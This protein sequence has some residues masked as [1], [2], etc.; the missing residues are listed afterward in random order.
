[1]NLKPIDSVQ[2]SLERL[3]DKRKKYLLAFSSGGDSV[4]LLY[5]LSFYFKESLKDHIAL[6]YINYH[7]SGL[8]KKK[9]ES[10]STMSLFLDYLISEKMST[11]ERTTETLK[12]GH[13]DSVTI[14]FGN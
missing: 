14:I 5:Q 4:F 1:M 13:V 7:D 12:T 6:V 3:V 2:T 9:K 10:S 8:V 11:I